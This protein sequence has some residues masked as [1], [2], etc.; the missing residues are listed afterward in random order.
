MRVLVIGSGGREHALVWKIAQS[1]LVEKVYCCPGNAG[2]SRV[3]EC[4]SLPE[5]GY[6]GLVLF[7]QEQEIG[8]VVVGPEQPLA[9]G[10]VDTY[11][12]AG[13]TV[14]GPSAAAARLEGSKIFAKEFMLRHH[15]PTAPFSVFDQSANAVAH[16]ENT[17]G[18]WVIKADGLAAGKGVIIC[19]DCQEAVNA[20]RQIMDDH[21]FGKAGHR[22]V[23]EDMLRGEEGSFIVLTD[24]KNIV[25]LATS[26]DHKAVF[27]DD[28]GPNTGGMG[29]YS[30][31]PVLE[32]PIKDTIMATIIK[33]TIRGMA[34]EGIPFRGVL[35]AGL[36]I[37]DGEP[38]V[39]EYNVRFGDPE[40]Q[41]ILTRL[42]SDLVPLLLG[43][44]RGD[45]PTGPLVWR[46]DFSII[47]I[48]T[49]GGYPGKYDQ[50]FEI[51]GLD[52]LEDSPDLVVF[53][54]GTKPSSSGY[55]TA[56]GRVLGITALGPT[57]ELTRQ[58][59]Y[60][61]VKRVHFDQCHYRT[62]IA[63]KALRR[64]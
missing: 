7:C 54:A 38:F 60:E 45:I 10:L 50:G 12:Q 51:S 35:Y 41:P 27:N 34:L 20:V 30:P 52:Q 63:A 25:P 62:D 59:V 46:D 23:I 53:H 13:L 55:L 40:T 48:L 5:D 8:L 21:I 42:T 9:D 39:L 58:K 11:R 17:P 6:E 14:F 32:G 31:A 37:V 61:A 56:G 19:H 3:A 28:R 49:S 47:V 36:M 1:P 24:G 16:L 57:I 64:F 29:A 18:P 26:Q 4:F 44:A 22:L 43:S 2:I 15:I 33:P